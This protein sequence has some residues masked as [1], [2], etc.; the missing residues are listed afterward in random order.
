DVHLFNKREGQLL[1]ARTTDPDGVTHDVTAQAKF[2]FADAK[3]AKIEKNTVRALADGKT[4]LRVEY[5][6]QVVSVPVVIEHA[7]LLPPTSFKRDV[8]P[9]FLRS[10]CNTGA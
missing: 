3:F 6:G 5:N 9:V 8:M 10:G 7:D 2:T 1:V 4:E